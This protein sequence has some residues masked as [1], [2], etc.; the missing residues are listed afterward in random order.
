MF[1]GA[2]NACHNLDACEITQN[3]FLHS[4]EIKNEMKIVIKHYE[5]KK[6]KRKY[7]LND[8]LFEDHEVIKVFISLICM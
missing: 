5:H 1:T 4:A 6:A 8:V 2:F 7:P 3:F